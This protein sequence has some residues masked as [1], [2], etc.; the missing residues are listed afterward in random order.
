M[1]YSESAR[2]AEAAI[3]L[4]LLLRSARFRSC[5]LLYRCSIPFHR[6][7]SAHGSGIIMK[8]LLTNYSDGPK[9]WVGFV[10]YSVKIHICKIDHNMYIYS[11]YNDIQISHFKTRRN[12]QLYR[13][14][15]DFLTSRY[16]LTSKNFQNY[17]RVYNIDML[18]YGANLFL[19]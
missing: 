10:V 6:I 16:A 18:S 13:P 1:V 15:C 3:R 11:K 12:L 8:R 19:N 9:L 2:N 7:F 14:I 5:R 17:Y 4:Y